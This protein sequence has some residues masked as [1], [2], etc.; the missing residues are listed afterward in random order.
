MKEYF[1]FVNDYTMRKVQG[2]VI[3][4]LG[5]CKGNNFWAISNVRNGKVILII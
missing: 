4:C 3:G 2:F 5:I 1:I